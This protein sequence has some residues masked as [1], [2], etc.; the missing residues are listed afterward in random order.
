[1]PNTD[2]YKIKRSAYRENAL[3]KMLKHEM[4]KWIR[5]NVKIDANDMEID[6]CQYRISKFLN[7]NGVNNKSMLF[8]PRTC[9]KTDDIYSVFRKWKRTSSPHEYI[10]MVFAKI[11]IQD[12][13]EDGYKQ[14]KGLYKLK[15]LESSEQKIKSS[16]VIDKRCFQQKFEVDKFE[17]DTFADTSAI[18]DNGNDRI[19]KI[20]SANLV[21]FGFCGP[22]I[23]TNLSTI[24]T[25]PHNVWPSF[26]TMAKID[27]SV[28][29]LC[30]HSKETSSTT[31][32]IAEML[33]MGIRSLWKRLYNFSDLKLDRIF[34]FNTSW[35]PEEMHTYSRVSSNG[36]TKYLND[37]HVFVRVFDGNEF[38][39]YGYGDDEKLQKT[40]LTN[41][42]SPAIKWTHDTWKVHLN[43]LTEEDEEIIYIN[44]EGNT[45]MVKNSMLKSD[46][47]GWTAELEKVLTVHEDTEINNTVDI[48]P[49]LNR[50]LANIDKKLMVQYKR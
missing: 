3:N 15:K 39:I 33:S 11:Q 50:L 17:V 10:Y 16:V 8:L 34:K 14:V 20:N 18:P 4:K 5:D 35:K 12:G 2:K 32:I 27:N 41:I 38:R 29:R 19:L 1:M 40:Q 49:E 7:A 37:T 43:K 47:I 9:D 42:G 45:F 36:F 23:N 13:R 24:L 44:I 46:D 26:C 28:N 25:T 6:E 30:Y 22:F 31:N 48:D 21:S